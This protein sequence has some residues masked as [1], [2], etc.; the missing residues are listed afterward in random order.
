MKETVAIINTVQD[1]F[2]LISGSLR[3]AFLLEF[4]FYKL[5][6]NPEKGKEEMGSAHREPSLL[7]LRA[8]PAEGSP[9]LVSK[10][11]LFNQ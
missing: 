3:T 7:P 1:V 4:W 5:T 6:Q 2:V 8:A 10:D 11:G 9:V